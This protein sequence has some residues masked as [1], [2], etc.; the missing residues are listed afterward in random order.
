MLNCPSARLPPEG[1]LLLTEHFR[2]FMLLV[3]EGGEQTL[4]VSV[5]Y[6]LFQVPAYGQYSYTRIRCRDRPLYIPMCLCNLVNTVIKL[7]QCIDSATQQVFFVCVMIVTDSVFA[8]NCNPFPGKESFILSFSSPVKPLT[9][10]CL[11]T[12]MGQLSQISFD[13][14]QNDKKFFDFFFY[15]TFFSVHTVRVHFLK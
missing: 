15:F 12:R 7:P 4:I 3:P 14:C 10:F 13:Q 2:N 6:S 5:P 1:A 8:L 9:S 11:N